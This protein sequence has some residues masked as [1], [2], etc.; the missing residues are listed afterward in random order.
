M[1]FSA[2]GY[3]YLRHF[4][5]STCT[6]GPH[7]ALFWVLP[8]GCCDET[9]PVGFCMGLPFFERTLFPAIV[10]NP[11]DKLL[12]GFI[13]RINF[14]PL[15][16]LKD[17]LLMLRLAW[18]QGRFPD[19]DLGCR[20][21]WQMVKIGKR[22]ITRMRMKVHE[23]HSPGTE[24][25]HRLRRPH[26]ALSCLLS[27]PGSPGAGCPPPTPR[28]VV[29]PLYFCAPVTIWR[30]CLCLYPAPNCRSS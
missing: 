29:F 3:I 22:P 19:F 23:E 18:I 20:N 14:H 26:S 30:S 8:E 27:S 13:E 5:T 12:G 9:P 11:S 21:Q 17:I 24:L 15:L 16:S 10:L 28:V 2:K 25:G 6:N 4:L 1:S 7:W